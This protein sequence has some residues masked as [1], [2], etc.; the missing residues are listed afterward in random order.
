MTHRCSFCAQEETP[1][2]KLVAGTSVFICGA[3]ASLVT[4]ILASSLLDGN[5]Y[6]SVCHSIQ[7]PEQCL[8]FEGRGYL[9]ADC[10]R[11]VRAATDS[12]IGVLT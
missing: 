1:E 11:E 9:C 7:S 3:C 12:T 4:E 5:V 8:I 6:C 10:V 2:R